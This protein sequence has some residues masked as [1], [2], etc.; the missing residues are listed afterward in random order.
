MYHSMTEV[1]SICGFVFSILTITT[2]II[3][4]MHL[5]IILVRYSI[6]LFVALCYIISWIHVI[7]L[8]TKKNYIDIMLKQLPSIRNF[9]VNQ[10]YSEL[11]EKN[12]FNIWALTITTLL[13]A[14]TLMM[15]F[16][17]YGVFIQPF[18]EM[19]H[20]IIFIGIVIVAANHF[21]F[22]QAD[23]NTL[24]ST[25]TISTSALNKK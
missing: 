11:E 2:L 7:I 12:A 10:L 19:C 1:F 24:I 18:S 22:Y 17:V 21:F 23:A 14:F 5:Q 9:E 15:S 16:T 6:T 20:T 3:P 8:N 25:I 4:L 13:S